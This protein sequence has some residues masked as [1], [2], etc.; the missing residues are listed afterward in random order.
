MMFIMKNAT[1][2][3]PT[4]A[5]S[6]SPPRMPFGK[7]HPYYH[8]FLLLLAILMILHNALVLY[9]YAKTRMLRNST[10][11]LLA[12]L[13]CADFVTGLLSIP[14]TIASAAL[15]FRGYDTLYLTSN[16]VNDFVTIIIVLNLLLI[17]M[18]RYIALCHPYIHPEIA[19]KSVVTCVVGG[20]WLFAVV[21]AL[22]QLVWTYPLLQGKEVDISQPYKIYSLVI[23]I[24]IFFVPSVAMSFCFIC[25]LSV[26]NRIVKEDTVRGMHKMKG[27]RSQKK[28]VLVFFAMFLNLLIC[29][30]P[31]M[32]IR[33][34]LD[35][36]DDF[37]PNKIVLESLL[38][39]RVCS[40]LFNPLIYV[41]CKKDFKR[42]FFRIFCK[43]RYM[44]RETT[45]CTPQVSRNHM[46]AKESLL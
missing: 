39:L 33:L 18:E 6:S 5:S 41:W 28:A 11:F 20:V 7:F 17:T 14:M 10:N 12:C 25:M 1:P 38:I 24:G 45:R 31:L 42:A 8:T 37:K 30:T 3:L 16:I 19:R 43:V 15:A 26:V 36:D 4:N 2:S 21:V 9:L 46:T 27:R 23:L 32:T 29:W 34:A 13:A 44:Q 35:I 22:I 40:S